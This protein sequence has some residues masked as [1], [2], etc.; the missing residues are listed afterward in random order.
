M[1]TTVEPEKML[2]VLAGHYINEKISFQKAFSGLKLSH[3]IMI[4]EEGAYL[5]EYIE[6]EPEPP[7]LLFMDSS[8]YEPDAMECVRQIRKD[9]RFSEM[10]IALYS[11]IQD[12]DVLKSYFVEGANICIR[13]PE[14]PEDLE[15]IIM[16]VVHVNW[17]YITNG[18]DREKFILKY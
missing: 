15:K 16:Q 11:D 18:L 8:I 1:N 17:Q 4:C 5:L 10:S 3:S 6:S 12:D 13:N 14:N 7:H 9:T 2:I